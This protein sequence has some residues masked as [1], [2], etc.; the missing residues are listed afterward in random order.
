MAHRFTFL[1]LLFA[2]A[3]TGALPAADKTPS[4]TMFSILGI[5]CVI[6]G[7]ALQVG[8]DHV[9]AVT[10]SNPLFRD[11]RAFKT[12]TWLRAIASPKNWGQKFSE[13]KELFKHDQTRGLPIQP[14]PLRNRIGAFIQANPFLD[15][16]LLMGI[17]CA[18]FPYM[19]TYK[20]NQKPA[21]PRVEPDSPQA[22][23]TRSSPEGTSALI[24]PTR[25][26]STH[27]LVSTPSPT[28]QPLEQ[29][30]RNTAASEDTPLSYSP[31]EQDSPAS[32]INPSPIATPA[33]T[34][35][36]NVEELL[37]E[38]TFTPLE[39]AAMRP[40]AERP[41]GRHTKK[42]FC[43]PDRNPTEQAFQQ[44]RADFYF[45]EG[46]SSA[47][48]FSP[49]PRANSTDLP[50]D[51]Q[52]AMGGAGGPPLRSTTP[53]TVSS[54]SDVSPI[55]TYR[56]CFSACVTP[57]LPDTSPTPTN[58]PPLAGK[59]GFQPSSRAHAQNKRP[60]LVKISS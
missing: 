23:P 35:A 11:S 2:T 32:A 50:Y 47:R 8:R 58:P 59:R 10:R 48:E 7:C 26:N 3:G 12:S 40:Q 49:I 51:A 15:A 33:R 25:T 27:S 18:C 28:F 41:A 53:E 55:D 38:M 44:F 21:T 4:K 29:T 60:T 14:Q 20:N 24:D 45:N 22:T 39:G 13:I 57:V 52:P 31:E 46:A 56:G 36:D 54:L 6:A 43:P 16:G 9:L 19:L 5:G 30:A 37:P 42:A 34:P 17:L 1:V